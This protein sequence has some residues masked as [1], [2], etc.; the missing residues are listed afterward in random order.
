M[1]PLADNPITPNAEPD[2]KT[3]KQRFL[4]L[5]QSRLRRV[6]DD[7]RP[8]QQDFIELLPLLFHVNHPILPGYVSKSTPVGVPEF[9][10]D[11]DT[12]DAAKRFSKSFSWKRR[13]YRKFEIHALYL[14]GSTG[15]IAY[16]DKSDFD[17]WVCHDSSL[18][19]KQLEELQEKTRAIENW[20]ASM[21]VEA[22]LFL[23]DAERF[24]R[25]EHGHLSSESSGSALHYLLLE[26]FYRTSVLLAGRYP[27]WWLVP[28][29]QEHNYDAV[30]EDI[31]LKRYLHSREHI[32]FGGLAHISADEFY[33]ATL[34]LLYKG[35]N[36]PYKSILKILLMEAYASEYP[37]IDLLGLRFKKAVYDGEDDINILDPYLMMMDKVEEY[38]VQ[39]NQDNRLDLARRSFYFKVDEPLSHD[40]NQKRNSWRRELM[41]G[42][43][44]QWGWSSGYIMKLDAQDEW[45][46]NSVIEERQILIREFT[47][48]YRFLSLF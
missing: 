36:S 6:K 43:T 27:I 22:N 26:E 15:T 29:E 35:I 28:P 25:G 45:N 33:G 34:W 3:L 2:F 16:S 21:G 7:L 13:A 4:K 10:P 39:Y 44:H 42:L 32:D 40:N 14:M 48:S 30:V 47:G 38:L 31:K 9:L 20:A 8:S 23:V 12:L 5:N 1:T 17:I 18:S 37:H 41:S 46:I 19:G 11:K 24:K